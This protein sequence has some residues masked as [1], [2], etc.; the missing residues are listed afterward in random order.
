VKKIEGKVSRMSKKLVHFGEIRA[1]D[2][3]L[4]LAPSVPFYMLSVM[5]VLTGQ[6]KKR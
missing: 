1:R 5:L 6:D 4:D 3:G 2:Y